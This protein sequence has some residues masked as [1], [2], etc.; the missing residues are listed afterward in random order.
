VVGDIANT[1]GVHGI[2]VAPESGRG[3]VTN[4]RGNDVTVFDLKTL[5]ET[6][7]IRAGEN[8]DTISYDR[9]TGRVFVF[10]GRSKNATVIDAKAAAVVAT[11][12]LPGKPEF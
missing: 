4:G 8:P 7:K 11:V 12:A 2:A 6:S 9:G 3:F 1:P 5:K 10:N